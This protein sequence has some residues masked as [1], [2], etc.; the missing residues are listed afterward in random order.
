MASPGSA[1]LHWPPST[2]H[3]AVIK[4]KHT[5]DDL[6]QSQCLHR[7][8]CAV[9][10]DRWQQTGK[11]NEWIKKISTNSADRDV[12]VRRYTV[13]KRGCSSKYGCKTK[14]QIFPLGKFDYL[15][16]MD[17]VPRNFT[18]GKVKYCD[19]DTTSVKVLIQICMKVVC[20]TH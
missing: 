12:I 10:A 8:Q 14:D 11:M 13:L 6:S 5:A 16:E 9:N 19:E 7:A 3:T 15:S 1:R 17:K 20:C 4:S 18:R 2:V